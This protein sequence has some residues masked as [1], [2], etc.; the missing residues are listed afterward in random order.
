MSVLNI[1]QIKFSPITKKYLKP[2]NNNQA[3]QERTLLL[4][5]EEKVNR[6][7]QSH[8]FVAGLGGVG[9]YAAEMLCR[10]G[11][12]AM[13]IADGDQVN[14]SNRNRQLLALHS[15]QGK[16]KALLMK[17]RLLD[18]NPNLELT[19]L[20]EFLRDERTDQVLET[21]FDYVVDAIDTLS[22]KIFLIRQALKNNLP[23]ASSMGAGGKMDPSQVMVADFEDTFHCNL[24]RILRKRLRKLGVTGGFKAVFSSE[25]TGEDS[26]CLIDNEP[27]KKSTVGT[28]SYMPAIFG[29]VLASVVIRDL[30]EIPYALTEKPCKNRKQKVREHQPVTG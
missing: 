18:I 27:N 12:G 25:F 16:R 5:K 19:V 1:W 4:L 23:L 13:T 10:A 3:W 7:Q 28:I 9:A 20:D 24:A 6:L 2:V 29:N 22:P 17:Q 8:V 26:I 15:T 30:L 11:V 14:P 21:P